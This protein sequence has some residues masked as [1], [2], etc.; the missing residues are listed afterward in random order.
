MGACRED[1]LR[2]HGMT[3]E[4][5]AHPSEGQQGFCLFK[6]WRKSDNEVELHPIP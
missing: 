6:N 5:E 1:S 2:I 3:G 4:G